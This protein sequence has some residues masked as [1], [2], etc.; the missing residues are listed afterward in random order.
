MARPATRSNEA[1]S[2]REK[3]GIR[4]GKIRGTVRHRGL[5]RSD[6]CF[7]DVDPAYVTGAVFKIFP[8]FVS[9]V[10]AVVQN[11]AAAAK[12]AYDLHA[13]RLKFP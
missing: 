1:G 9:L 2:K 4:D 3:V 7:R 13:L 8:G 12:V 5:R 6:R 10:T 11:G